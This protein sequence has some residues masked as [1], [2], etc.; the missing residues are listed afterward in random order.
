MI[1]IIGTIIGSTLVFGLMSADLGWQNLLLGAAFSSFFMWLLRRQLIPRPLP[2]NG[3][4][5]HLLVYFP[6]LV[7]YLLID[8]LKGTWQVMVVTL[9]IRP[10]AKP[11]IVKLPIAA[12]SPYGVGPVGYFITLSPGSFM[13]DVDWDDGAMYVHVIDASD[14]E[15]IRRDAEKYYRLWEYGKYKPTQ[16]KLPEEEEADRRA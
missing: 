8:I 5:L 4:A 3:F 7:W 2:E 11:G 13:I 14:P 12:H 15:M 16:W 6:V 1:L 10:L 9:G